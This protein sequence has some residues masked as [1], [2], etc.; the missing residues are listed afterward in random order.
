M[1]YLIVVVVS[2]L[3]GGAI[4]AVTLRNGRNVEMAFGFGD[5]GDH[6]PDAGVAPEPGYAYLRVATTRPSWRD[7]VLGFAGL[8]LLVVASAAVLALGIYQVGHLVN[9]LIERFLEK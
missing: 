4:Y 7:R 1:D 8:V 6:D 2:L 9:Q 3:V 5:E